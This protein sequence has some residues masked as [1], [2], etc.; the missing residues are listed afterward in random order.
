MLP[1]LERCAV[2]KGSCV[3][4]LH[5]KLIRLNISFMV[6]IDILLVDTVCYCI[7]FSTMTIMMM[8]MMMMMQR[9]KVAGH[10]MTGEALKKLQQQMKVN[11]DERRLTVSHRQS[12]Q[13]Q[14]QIICAAVAALY[15]PSTAS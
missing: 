8:V 6:I 3:Q 12:L 5:N 10:V 2:H 15:C 13:L 14:P 1:T 9:A 4:R 11:R 7:E